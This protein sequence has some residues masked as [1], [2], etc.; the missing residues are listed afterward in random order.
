MK[1]VVHPLHGG[2]SFLG[3]DGRSWP[4]VTLSIHSVQFSRVQL[5][6][7]PMDCSMPGFPVHTNSQSL[8]K[9]MSIKSVMSS[10]HPEHIYLSRA[11]NYLEHSSPQ[12]LPH[13]G[14]DL[15]RMRLWG[16]LMVLGFEKVK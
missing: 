8:L 1:N 5:F 7:T 15:S 13:T 11:S 6:V 12:T 10:N 3:M 16:G 9:L 2:M 14:E 4:G